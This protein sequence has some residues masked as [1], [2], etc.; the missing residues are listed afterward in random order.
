MGG[1]GVP[2]LNINVF[3]ISGDRNPD[4]TLGVGNSL[5]IKDFSLN[6][7]LDIRRGGDV[8]N[9]N[10][11]F[12]F[13]NG[14]SNRFLNR[15]QPYIFKGVLRDGR[16]NSESPT[17]NTLAVVPQY[18][19]GFFSAFSP[20]DFIE[21]DINWVRLRELTL[22][23]NFPNSIIG[24]NRFVRSASVFL[25]GNDLFII[26]NYTGADPSVNGNTAGSPGANAAGFDYGTLANP[27]AVTLGV[28]LGI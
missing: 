3:T 24:G 14:Y 25:T 1:T 6:F 8:F 15:D 5:T 11:F 18:Q 26:T 10:E 4:F 7:L 27:R 13:Q 19:N 2:E 12:L 21:R 23:Y 28:R 16:E 9:G 17:P 20:S 22:S